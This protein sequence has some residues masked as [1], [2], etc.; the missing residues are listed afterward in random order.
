MKIPGVCSFRR[1]IHSR[2]LVVVLAV[3][4]GLCTAAVAT[5]SSDGGHHEDASVA[6]EHGDSGHHEAAAEG[7]H[8]E[9]E[10]HGEGHGG[11]GWVKTDTYRVMNFAV[12]AVVL[13]FLLRKPVSQALNARIDSIKEQLD[14]LESKKSGAEAELAEY[15]SKIST[16]EKEAEEIVAEYI[17][18]GE[19]AKVRILKEAESSADKL[20]EQAERNIAYEFKQARK[21]LQ[22]EIFAK[23]MGR[24]EELLRSSITDSDQDRLVDEYLQKVVTQ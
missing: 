5:A 13:F 11:K 7:G 18:Q 23:A 17:R 24:A 1:L 21:Q 22:D 10:A 20:E 6:A 12:L 3:V 15:K 9:G 4:M 19:E 8:G 16:L 2:M 14:D